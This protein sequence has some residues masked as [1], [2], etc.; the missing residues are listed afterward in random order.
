M[1]GRIWALSVGY[2][3]VTPSYVCLIFVKGPEFAQS[4]MP[5]QGQV[6]TRSENLWRYAKISSG[7]IRLPVSYHVTRAWPGKNYQTWSEPQQK[8]NIKH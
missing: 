6:S 3:I 7:M 4:A 2:F 1:L 5:G 8:F